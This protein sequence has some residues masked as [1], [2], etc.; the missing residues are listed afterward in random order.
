MGGTKVEHAFEINPDQLAWLQEMVESY[1][2]AD[3]AKALRILL[4]YAMSDGDR[5]LIFDE[6]RCHH[7]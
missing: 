1:A 3:E 2:L 7:C 5:D 4:D 6:I